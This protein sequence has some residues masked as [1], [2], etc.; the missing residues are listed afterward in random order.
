MRVEL[1]GDVARIV[2]EEVV[3]RK[4]LRRIPRRFCLAGPHPAAEHKGDA[5]ALARPLDD[6]GEETEDPG[7][8]LLVAGAGIDEQMIAERLVA[9][10]LGLWLD[11]EAGP[12]VQEASGSLGHVRVRKELDAPIG[13]ALRAS[14]P[15]GRPGDGFDGSLAVGE[16]GEPVGVPGLEGAD[17]QHPVLILGRR[18]GLDQ[19]HHGPRSHQD[20]RLVLVDRLDA[21]APSA[22]A[23][24]ASAAG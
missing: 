24:V 9:V 15:C 11:R 1:A 13:A 4:E 3:A 18:V 2:D 6:M 8:K 21:E 20:E 12:K 19:E 14:Q 23:I 7:E 22:R 16:F 5:D 17:R 10:R